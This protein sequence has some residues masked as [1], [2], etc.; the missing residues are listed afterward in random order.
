MAD[1]GAGEMKVLQKFNLSRL[2]HL[3]PMPLQTASVIGK[4]E[5]K[6]QK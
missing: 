1:G 3:R 2:F 6:K 5:Q 4:L